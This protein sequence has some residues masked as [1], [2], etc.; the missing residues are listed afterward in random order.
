MSDSQKYEQVNRAIKTYGTT[1]DKGNLDSYS[2]DDIKKAKSIHRAN[3]I[4]SWFSK[5]DEIIEEREKVIEQKIETHK[6]YRG[7]AFGYTA[8][9]ITLATLQIGY[10]AGQIL[11]KNQEMK[12]SKWQAIFGTVGLAFLVFSVLVAVLSQFYIFKGYFS[13]ARGNMSKANQRY[14]SPADKMMRHILYAFLA[15]TA[16]TLVIVHLPIAVVVSTTFVGFWY[17]Y[18]K[19]A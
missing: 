1:G 18:R 17:F 10:L 11:I 12:V 7:I 14:F 16:A 5:Y 4:Q 6:H 3:A 9:V 13:E 2:T 19:R 15:G 8:T